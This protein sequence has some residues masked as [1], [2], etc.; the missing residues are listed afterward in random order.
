MRSRFVAIAGAVAG[1]VALLPSAQGQL[2]QEKPGEAMPS[3]EVAAVRPNKS[4]S[5]REQIWHNDN[6]WRVENLSLRELIAYA[7]GAASNYQ[8]IGGPG[9]L[10]DERFDISAKISDADTARL[11]KLSSIDS[12]RQVDLMLQG[13]LTDRFN[14]K[15]HVE[16]KDLPVYALVVAKSGIRFHPSVPVPSGKPGVPAVPHTSF[17][18][19]MSRT[20]AHVSVTN[21]TLQ[22]SL[23]R[24]LGWQTETQGRPLVD[25]TGLT[26]VYDFDLKWTP[27]YLWANTKPGDNSSSADPGLTA[28][29]LFTALEDQLGL[30]LESEKK[31]TEVFIIDHVEPPSAN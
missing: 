3:F 27:E 9:P 24:L 23:V 14:L 13:L 1:A 31:S 7:W 25:A 28:S 29:S 20:G 22:S 5:G 19:Q 26:G 16:T 10:L 2:V 8:V 18:V 17:N 12:D 11:A 6:S 30:K 4:G 15:G 21:R